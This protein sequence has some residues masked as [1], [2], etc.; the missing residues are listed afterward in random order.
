VNPQFLLPCAC[1]KTIPVEPV[2]AGN[3]IHCQCG[4]EL[5]IPTLLAMRRLERVQDSPNKGTSDKLVW[6]P[7]QRLFVVG[8]LISAT[9]LAMA[10]WFYAT[11][12]RKPDTTRLPPLLTLMLWESLKTGVG[13]PP[14]P[15]EQERIAI[16]AGHYR[17]A[18]LGLVVAVIG[19]AVL[20]GS[21]CIR[22]SRVTR[23]D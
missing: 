16:L 6:G 10:T 7:K 17:W 19:A 11:R 9:G 1:G 15:A 2:Q 8:I 21:L 18:V 14:T 4:A 5:Q 22:G 13:T 3:R 20:A 12:P 23:A